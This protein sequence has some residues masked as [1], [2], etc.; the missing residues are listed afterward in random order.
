MPQTWGEATFPMACFALYQADF[1]QV[2][3]DFCLN[4]D[5]IITPILGCL[6]LLKNYYYLF[7]L[8]QGFTMYTRLALGSLC[9]PGWLQ[10]CDP[11]ASSSLV[12]ELQVCATYMT[13]CLTFSCLVG[14]VLAF[15]NTGVWTQSLVLARQELC[16]LNY[17]RSPFCFSYFSSRVPCFFLSQHGQRFCHLRLP[18]SWDHR[19]NFNGWEGVL[20]TFCLVFLL[21]VL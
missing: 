10:I 20:L 16:L 11:P 15:D 4:L 19:P 14:W 6:M 3:S 21:R 7:I 12:L 1:C 8:R 2:P 13:T 17:T 9:S 5:V 18:C